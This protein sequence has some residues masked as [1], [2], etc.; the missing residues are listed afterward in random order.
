MGKSAGV[1]C[2][3]SSFTS[4]FRLQL[5]Y[6]AIDGRFL[7][8]AVQYVAQGLSGILG[9]SRG[10]CPHLHVRFLSPIASISQLPPPPFYAGHVYFCHLSSCWYRLKWQNVHQERRGGCKSK[11]KS[12]R[13]F[14]QPVICEHPP[15]ICQQRREESADGRILDRPFV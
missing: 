9:E 12:S 5:N 2:S 7:E 6:W 15:L 14:Y 13:L 1:S 11:Q 8:A 3:I 10:V 4:F